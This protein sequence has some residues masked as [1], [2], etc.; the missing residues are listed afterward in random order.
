MGVS[1]AY[2]VNGANLLIAFIVDKTAKGRAFALSS[3]F[4]AGGASLGA[5]GVDLV[6]KG[7]LYAIGLGCLILLVSI[8][9][10]RYLIV[11]IRG[12]RDRTLKIEKKSVF[13]ILFLFPFIAMISCGIGLDQG[14]FRNFFVIFIEHFYRFSQGEASVVFSLAFIGATFMPLFFGILGDKIGM[15]KSLTIAS[16]LGVLV[17]LLF[18][19]EYHWSVW[20]LSFVWGGCIR[21][22]FTL[23]LAYLSQ[24]ASADDLPEIMAGYGML[25]KFGAVLAPLIIGYGI[26]SFG[27]AWYVWASMVATFAI[28]IPSLMLV[29]KRA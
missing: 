28:F 10:S 18:L 2:L 3:V 6:G 1:S 9:L 24:K 7:T 16:L 17:L 23:G 22:C 21:T 19:M 29:I 11:D 25:G 4:A 14:G 13:G 20:V 27:S 15:I 8:F 26:S 12:K 5:A